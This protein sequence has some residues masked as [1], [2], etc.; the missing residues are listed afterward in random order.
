MWITIWHRDCY[1]VVQGVFIRRERRGH[2]LFA[3]FHVGWTLGE[4]FGTMVILPIAENVHT[5]PTVL[6]HYVEH[7]REP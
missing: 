7:R 4:N 5:D 2:L 3:H 1:E 6:G